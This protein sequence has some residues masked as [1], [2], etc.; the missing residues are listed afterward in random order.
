MQGALAA[1]VI[2]RFSA[3]PD[4]LVSGIAKGAL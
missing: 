1:D 3:G 4:I 2:P